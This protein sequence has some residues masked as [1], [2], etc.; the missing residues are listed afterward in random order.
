MGFFQALKGN[1]LPSGFNTILSAFL[2]HIGLG[3]GPIEK[4]FAGKN[5]DLT[6]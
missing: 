2:G 3:L 4:G 6:N 1:P 5:Q